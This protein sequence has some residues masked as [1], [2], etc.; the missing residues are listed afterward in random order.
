MWFGLTNNLEF[1]QQLNARLTGGHRAVGKNIVIHHII[2]DDTAD[3]DMI[4][5][6]KKKDTDQNDLTR[7]L[8][9]SLQTN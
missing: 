4:E 7:A 1:Y 9:R 2:A 5:L 3:E 8:V 6:L